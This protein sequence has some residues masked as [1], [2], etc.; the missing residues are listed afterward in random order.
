MIKMC[1]KCLPKSHIYSAML[2][3]TATS[4]TSQSLKCHIRIQDPLVRAQSKNLLSRFP[5]IM[6]DSPLCCFLST[7]ACS[8]SKGFLFHRVSVCECAVLPRPLS[9]ISTVTDV[10]HFPSSQ[11]CAGFLVIPAQASASESTP[12]RQ[13]EPEISKPV[14]MHQPITWSQACKHTHTYTHFK[15]ENFGVNTHICPS[16]SSLPPTRETL[17]WIHTDTTAKWNQAALWDTPCQTCQTGSVDSHACTKKQQHTATVNW[18]FQSA[19]AW[20]SLWDVN[21]DH[22]M[23]LFLSEVSDSVMNLSVLLLWPAT[24]LQSSDGGWWIHLFTITSDTLF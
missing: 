12:I 16:V 17:T 14:N 10:L 11:D 21:I 4:W 20:E 8:R 5:H 7:A 24:K 15:E 19:C 18:S 6:K 1:D 9:E 3:N 22:L 13:V 23:G 2:R